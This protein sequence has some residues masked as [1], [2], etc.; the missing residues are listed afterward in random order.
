MDLVHGDFCGHILL[1]WHKVI[2]A[3]QWLVLCQNHCTEL[4]SL[5]SLSTNVFSSFSSQLKLWLEPKRSV[6]PVGCYVS[7]M[8]GGQDV[9]GSIQD[10]FHCNQYGFQDGFQQGIQDGCHQ[11]TKWLPIWLLST[12]KMVTHCSKSEQ[13]SG[14]W[15]KPDS[16]L[17]VHQI[18]QKMHFWQL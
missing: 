14:V 12:F 6:Q 4:T 8:I 1:L 10:G 16:V 15:S 11:Q 2:V 18:V 9:D 7:V 5:C 13:K 3:A 17:S